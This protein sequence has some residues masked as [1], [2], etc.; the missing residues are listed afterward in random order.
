MATVKVN[1]KE[2]DLSDFAKKIMLGLD[3]SFKK[4]VKQRSIEDGSLCFSDENG[5]VYTVQAKEIE[6]YYGEN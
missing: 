1:A 4:L 6:R 2:K 5:R 3:I